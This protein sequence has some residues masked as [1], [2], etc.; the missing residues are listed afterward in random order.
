MEPVEFELVPVEEAEQQILDIQSAEEIPEASDTIMGPQ[1]AD[2]G[3]IFH[4]G[5]AGSNVELLYIGNSLAQH[6]YRVL[7]PLLPGH[8]THSDDML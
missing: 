8:G 1:D 4:H 6:G 5:F 2:M 3:I 7:I